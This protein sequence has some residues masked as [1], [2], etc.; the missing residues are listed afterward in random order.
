MS[1]CFAMIIKKSQGQS[2]KQVT[3][4][5]PQPV[6]SHEQLYIAISRVTSRGGLEILI[7]EENGVSMDST[8]N[9]LQGNFSQCTNMNHFFICNFII[10][11]IFAS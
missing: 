4:Y 3:M 7:T 10:S 11:I 2:L 1:V 9:V 8:S 5:L 6:F